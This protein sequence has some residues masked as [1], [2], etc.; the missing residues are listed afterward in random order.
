[1][2]KEDFEK[3]G[4]GDLF[5]KNDYPLAVL[6]FVKYHSKMGLVE[7]T[8]KGVNFSIKLSE[9]HNYSKDP[10]ASIDR[11]NR[12]INTLNEHAEDFKKEVGNEYGI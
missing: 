12:T 7:A 8:T 9:I 10:Q 1:M 5:F 3:M 11:I 4:K 6:R 2:K